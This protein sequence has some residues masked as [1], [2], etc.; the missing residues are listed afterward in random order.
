MIDL[1]TD[2][3]LGGAGSPAPSPSSLQSLFPS[4]GKLPRVPVDASGADQPQGITLEADTPVTA[5]KKSVG[6]TGTPE[7]AAAGSLCPC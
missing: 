2:I 3:Y 5:G 1:E 7:E 4:V 6:D